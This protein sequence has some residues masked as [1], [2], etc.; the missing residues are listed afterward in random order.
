LVIFG[1]FL[2]IFASVPEHR[3]ERRDVELDDQRTERQHLS[4]SFKHQFFRLVSIHVY[5]VCD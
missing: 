4:G 3:V 5:Q 2:G 1:F